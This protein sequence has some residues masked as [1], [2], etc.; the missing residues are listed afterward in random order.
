MKCEASSINKYLDKNLNIFFIYGSEIILKNNSKDLIK[1]KLLSKGFDEKKIINKNDFNNIEQQIIENAGGS[2]FG[3]KVIIEINHDQGRVPDQ[4]SKIFQIPNIDKMTNIALIITSHNDK[5]NSATNWVKAMDEIALIIQCKKLKSFEEKIWLKHQLDFVHEKDKPTLIQNISEMNSGNLVA[6]QN[7]VNVLKLL[8]K[9]RENQA[10][11]SSMDSAEFVP[12]E[13]ED[14]I[15]S[16]NTKDALRIIHSIKNSEAHYAPL[17]VWIIGKIINSASYARQNQNPK[18]SLEKSGV[19]KNKISA[20]MVF[21]KHHSLKKLI[22]LQ[23]NVFELDIVS[24][25]LVKKDFWNE[26]DDIVIDLTSN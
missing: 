5:L 4:I 17:L 1:R 10:H 6:Q 7:E 21:I 22:Q 18:I 9:E 3:S 16:R 19:W 13:L 15:I 23:K 25:G 14:M 8:Y 20:Y 11:I 26:L 24:K 2:L 12:F